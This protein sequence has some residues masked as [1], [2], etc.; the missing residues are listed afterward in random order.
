VEHVTVP[1]P[2]GGERSGERELL[3]DS[4][5]FVSVMSPATDVLFADAGL[6]SMSKRHP[7]F[8]F[9][10][11]VNKQTTAWKK[12]SDAKRRRLE[13]D[14]AKHKR[15]ALSLTEHY[16]REAR[17]FQI[18][19]TTTKYRHRV[20]WFPN[21]FK[22]CIAFYNIRRRDILSGEGGDDQV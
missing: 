16:N 21:I 19:A 17:R 1:A 15:L 13:D 18:L 20:D 8:S 12:A 2:A 11:P 10:L 14:D 9:L 5:F 6:R 3:D 22:I 7:S 4:N